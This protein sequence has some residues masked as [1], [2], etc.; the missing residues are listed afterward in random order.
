MQSD[1][2]TT[3]AYLHKQMPLTQAMGLVVTCASDELAVV[4]APLAPNLNH[5]QTAFGG[6]I[7]TIGITAGWVYLHCRLEREGIS[8]RLII[9]KSQIEYLQPAASDFEARCIAPAAHEWDAFIAMLRKRGRARINRSAQIQCQGKIAAIHH[10]SYVAIDEN[11]AR[12]KGI[13]G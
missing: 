2:A 8:A 12:Q 9:Q 6:S 3:T 13:R 7:A 11:L 5:Q 1:P 4:T 10:G